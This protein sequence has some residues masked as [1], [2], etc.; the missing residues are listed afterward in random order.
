GEVSVDG[1]VMLS[2]QRSGAV[3]SVRGF[4]HP[5]SLARRVMDHTS[6]L[7][8]AGHGAEAF[9]R[10]QEF[11]EST[12]LTEEAEA[13]WRSWQTDESRL[14]DDPR[15]KGWLPARNIEERRG[16]SG[17]EE[18][19]DEDVRPAHDRPSDT[20]GVLAIDADGEMAGACSTSG[21]AFKRP[22]RVGDSPI[23]GHGLYVEPGVGAAVGTG[24][25]ELIMSVCGAFLAVE[26]LRRGASPHAAALTV[27][28]R[29]A[30]LHDLRDEHQAV[31]LVMTPDGAWSAA[32]LRPGYRTAVRRHD[33]DDT[34][35]LPSQFVLYPEPKNTN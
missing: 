18:T 24:A 10:E 32:A 4:N 26:E 25:G 19:S 14:R 33:H 27:I 31:L 11:P 29:I 34:L 7:L 13:Q 12:M 30:A 22:G 28:E 2:P 3:C 20:V 1:C 23:I 8:L 21:M 15:F 9:A 16:Y 5:V 6:H 35:M 17:A